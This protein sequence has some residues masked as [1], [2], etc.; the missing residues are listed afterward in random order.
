MED[1]EDR[2]KIRDK[3]EKLILLINTLIIMAGII[4]YR[5]EQAKKSSDI[6]L[7]EP[8]STVYQQDGQSVPEIDTTYESVTTVP[9]D[10][11]FDTGIDPDMCADKQPTD[12]HL[13]QK[14]MYFYPI[15]NNKRN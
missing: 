1:T 13:I 6:Y 14:S 4:G 5:I 12:S 7:P 9:N 2:N 15:S 8:V 11:I 3:I 10:E